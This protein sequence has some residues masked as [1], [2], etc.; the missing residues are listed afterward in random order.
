MDKNKSRH[1]ADVVVFAMHSNYFYDICLSD[2][3][4]GDIVYRK[5]TYDLIV[6]YFLIRIKECNRLFSL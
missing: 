1:F 6:F 5:I 2:K 4:K 3:D